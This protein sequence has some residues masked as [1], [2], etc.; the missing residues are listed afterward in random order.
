VQI[1]IPT[2]LRQH[3]SG[4]QFIDTSRTN[5]KDVPY[6]L[7]YTIFLTIWHILVDSEYTIK[8][9]NVTIIQA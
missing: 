3:N 1:L 5:L 4:E 2:A 8:T 7:I 9:I 6:F